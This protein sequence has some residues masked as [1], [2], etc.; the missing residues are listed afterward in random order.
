MWLLTEDSSNNVIYNNPRKEEGGNRKKRK[1]GS[2]FHGLE[3]KRKKVS[4][5]NGFK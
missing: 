2:C 4:R 5:H 1:T 3:T